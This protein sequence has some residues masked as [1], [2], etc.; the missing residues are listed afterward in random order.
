MKGRHLLWLLAIGS[1]LAGA[2]E[3]GRLFFTPEQRALL[4]LAQH[5]ATATDAEGEGLTLNG[6]VLRSDGR[7]TVWVNGRQKPD[8]RA[9]GPGA[10]L[11]PLPAVPAKVRL[12]VGQTIDPATGQVGEQLRRPITSTPPPSAKANRLT[13]PNHEASQ[14]DED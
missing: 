1:Q 7:Q 13:R 6:I 2:D 3:L 12:K 4:E 9:V 5:Q 10:A 14:A 11:I 8:A